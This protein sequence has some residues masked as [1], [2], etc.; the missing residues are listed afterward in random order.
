MYKVELDIFQ[1]P[2]DLLLHLI[3]KME[4]DIHQVSISDLTDSYLSYLHSIDEISLSN[5]EEYIVMA[6]TLMHLKSKSLLPKEEIITGEDYEDDIVQQLIDYKNYK[7][8]C[9]EL[10]ELYK[11]RMNY[12]EKNNEEIYLNGNLQNIP[13][14]KL[15][16]TFK[17]IIRKKTENNSTITYRKEISIEEIITYIK[18]YLKRNKY[19]TFSQL[20]TNYDTKEE[21]I[22]TFLAILDLIKKDLVI[23]NEINEDIYIEIK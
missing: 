13:V 1:G 8:I 6:S 18:S 11:K 16:R 15:Y 14:E 23:F 9:L 10:D 5:A 4:L 19:I 22:V 12:G 3:E 17:N 21:I 7:E 2:L 20:I